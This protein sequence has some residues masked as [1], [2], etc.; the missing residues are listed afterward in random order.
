MLLIVGLVSLGHAAPQRHAD[1]GTDPRWEGYRNRL[2]PAPLPRTRQDFGYRSSNQARGEKSGEIGGYIQRSLTP[3]SY[4]K[5]IPTRTLNDKLTASGR[6]A[7]TRDESNSGVLF[8]WFHENS[9]GWRTPNSLAFRLDGNGG[10]YWVF[11]EYGTRNWLTGGGVTFEGEQYQTTKTKPFPADGTSHEWSLTYDPE[12]QNGLG[13]ITFKLDGQ[14][15]AANLAPGHK[16]DGATFNRFGIWNQH[17]SGSGMEA[18]FDDVVIDGE[19]EDFGRDPGWIGSGNAIEFDE[20][21]IRPKH[22]FGYSQTQHAGGDLGEIGGL[23]WRDEATAYY[24]DRVGPLT[25]TNELYASGKLSFNAAGSDSAVYIGWFNSASKTNKTTPEHREPQRDLLAILIEGPSRVGHY[26]RPA[27]RT[28]DGTGRLKETGPLIKPEGRVH[29]WSIRYRPEG[30]GQIVVTFD[31]T[32]QE[33]ALD[34]QHK[35]K[36]AIFDR[37]GLFNVQAGGHHVEVYL[38]DLS[39]TAD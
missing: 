35:A 25:L 16:V 8:G 3:A 34:P 19:R 5:P 15:Y 39:Y 1:F 17:T 9:R 13:Q 32:V 30:A 29:T 36:G 37:F 24:G 28:R 10:K 18:W 26:F 11:F 21:A 20:R 7:V 33:L 22:D 14:S 4:A 12:G 23:I 27:Y 38:D 2:L 6:F 31:D